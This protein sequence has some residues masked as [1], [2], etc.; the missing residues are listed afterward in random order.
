MVDDKNNSLEISCICKLIMIENVQVLL[1]THVI[2]EIVRIERWLRSYFIHNAATLKKTN[3]IMENCTWT[4][5][6]FK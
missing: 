2:V 1:S 5:L 3:Y 6:E 4:C